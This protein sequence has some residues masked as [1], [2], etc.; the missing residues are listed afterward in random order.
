MAHW[1]LRRIFASS[2]PWLTLSACVLVAVFSAQVRAQYPTANLT[3]ISPAGAKVGSEVE[4][5]ISGVDLD[6]VDKL[7]FSHPGITAAIK[8]EGPNDFQKSAQPVENT[9]LVKI[10]DNV[11][12]GVHEAR[13]VGRYGM[14][15]PRAFHVG[16]L[17]EAADDGS[18][19][20]RD[21]AAEVALGTIVNGQVEGDR[22]DYF[23]LS[24]TKGQRILVDC[25]AQRIDSRMDGTL[26][27]LDPTGTE[28]RRVRDT[29]GT[30]PVLDFTAPSDG[31][32]LLGVFDFVYGGGGE[33]FYRLAVHNGP[34]IDFVFPPVGQ[35]GKSGKFTVYGRNL[36]GG[37]P[38]EGLTVEGAALEQV[39]VDIN[40]PGDAN[41]T[42]QLQVA[43]L[44]HPHQGPIDAMTYQLTGPQGAS[45]TVHIGFASAPVVV[46][47]EGND[48]PAKGQQVSIP[49]EY[50]GQFFPRGDRDWIQFEAKQGDVYWIDVVSHQ[51][52]LS[53]DPFLVVE[54]VTKNDKGE[55][56]VSQVAT[57][58]DAGQANNNNQP[59]MFDMRSND[60]RYRFEAKAD[61]TY[62]IGI[63]DLYGDSRGDPRMVYRLIIRKAEPDFRLVAYCEPQNNRNQFDVCASVLRRGGATPLKV[64]IIRRDGFQGEVE[65]TAEN[66][67][68]GVTCGG[69]IVGGDSDSAE[70]IFMADENA[71]A[72]AGNIQVVGKSTIDGQQV[73]RQ[74][75]GGSLVWGTKN[76]QQELPF[77]RLTRD[78]GLSVM[79]KETEPVSVTAGDGK[80]IETSIGGKVELPIKVARRNGFSGAVKLKA[81]GLPKD[82]QAKDAD[83]G[84]GDGKMEIS[85]ANNRIPAG[86]YTFYL[87]TPVKFKY[88]RNPEALEQAKARQSELDQIL[89]E[90][91][92]KAKQTADAA[93][94]ARDE[95]NKNKEDKG[96]QDA[97][98]K[99][100]EE[101]KQAEEKRKQADN[102]K[103]SADQNVKN[104]EN[105]NKPKDITV[106]V[107]SSPVLLR[108][109]AT[110]ITLTAQAPGGK[111]KQG[112]MLEIPV[113]VERKF[114][115][116]DQIELTLEPPKGVSG[117]S[118]GKI[119]LAKGQN[120]GKLEVKLAD[121]ATPGDHEFTVRGRV[122]FN[123]VQLDETL[124]VAL[125]IETK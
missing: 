103:K 52:G 125:A 90:L 44:M 16:T 53:T 99:A 115:F 107:I 40:I 98:Q 114:G 24:L 23:K 1:M 43:S 17:N 61:A 122:K 50:S 87:T 31:E 96:L 26:L 92:E 58:D 62:R 39:E 65:I 6:S 102:L 74:A 30:D 25:W 111:A 110:P 13:A 109:A 37:K 120:Q 12:P 84:G 72:W 20:S 3:S 49:C 66:L 69:A 77:A 38:V 86:S 32:Y 41:V 55:E 5:K 45:N 101:S 118:A 124:P 60:P 75:R 63:S 28:L 19:T 104:I 48:D 91:T 59:Q 56:N 106:N 33:Y 4:V 42:R 14:T 27:L 116:D 79:D 121:N 119:S 47:T 80:V 18:N 57:M 85:L 9:F 89:K 76:I 51:L 11:P 22:I 35:P 70:L 71:P 46:E 113:T 34:F 54:Q 82:V 105:A 10:A 64:A 68:Q 94:K 36:P 97:A 8:M 29:E 108:L 78:I 100:E 15:N 7:V 112:Q 117:V 73:T 67:P 81:A 88:T 123:N 83:V 21:K 95:A 2:S 93:K